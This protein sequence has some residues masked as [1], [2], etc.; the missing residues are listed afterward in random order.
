MSDEARTLATA[1]DEIIHLVNTS[2]VNALSA[3]ILNRH[4]QTFDRYLSTFVETPGVSEMHA[5]IRIRKNWLYN[6]LTVMVDEKYSFSFLT[7]R[8]QHEYNTVEIGGTD[9]GL[10]LRPEAIRI[11]RFVTNLI[12]EW[13]FFCTFVRK[14]HMVQYLRSFRRAWQRLGSSFYQTLCYP[15]EIGTL[16]KFY[17]AKILGQAMLGARREFKMIKDE[18][19]GS[20]LNEVLRAEAMLDEEGYR[21]IE[22]L[23]VGMNLAK[24]AAANPLQS[25][26]FEDMQWNL[27]EAKKYLLRKVREGNAEAGEVVKSVLVDLRSKLETAEYTRKMIAELGID[28]DDALSDFQIRKSGKGRVELVWRKSG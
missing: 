18:H 23:E 12:G 24:L 15:F 19:Y 7:L 20:V 22:R 10:Y 21:I 25:R 14:S 1:Y 9:Q 5:T 16:S 4:F 2:R 26:K 28:P 3:P 17:P 8:D 6:R 13:K 11:R 27:I